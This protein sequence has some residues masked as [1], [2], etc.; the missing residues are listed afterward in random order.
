MITEINQNK[1]KT[2]HVYNKDTNE[3]VVNIT[4][5]PQGNKLLIQGLEK[6]RR[7]LTQ[8]SPWIGSLNNK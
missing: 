5:I 8:Q 1:N 2:I 7:S 4:Y 3:N 6:S